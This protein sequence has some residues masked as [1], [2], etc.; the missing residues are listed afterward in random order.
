[1]SHAAPDRIATLDIIRGVAVLGILAMNVVDFA[2]P[3]E[4]YANPEAYGSQGAADYAA[5][6]VGFILFDGKMR[7]LF[8]LLFGASMLLVIER[9]DARGDNSASIHFRRMLWLGMIGLLHFYL[10]WH[11]DILFGYA[12]AGMAAWFFHQQEPEELLRWGM[13]FLLVEFALNAVVSAGYFT[14]AAAAAAP[15]ATAR[16]VAQWQAIERSHGAPGSAA[17][18]DT[19]ALYR[20]PYSGILHYRLTA[21]GWSPFKG[22]LLYTWE[23]IGFMLLGMAALKSGFLIGAWPERRYRR[24]AAV[25][26]GVSLPAYA[27]LAWLIARSGF[28][29]PMLAAAGD[30]AAALVRP[31]MV[32]GLA[33]AIILLARGGMLTRRIAAAGRAA[34]TNYLGASLLMTSLFY[35]Y[36]FGLFGQLGRAELWLAVLPAWALMLLWPAPWL[37]R[38]LYGP[39]EWLWR[40]LA[41]GTPQPM[42]R[43]RVAATPG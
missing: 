32:I 15:D 14:M 17:I 31:A 1:M 33:A 4:A 23:A 16:A 5:W 35:G 12:V 13:A 25:A 27:L 11:G 36:G 22:L 19:L 41:R 37:E 3:A 8:S 40:S 24:V 39:F 43:R 28:S 18:A 6:A 29:V 34:F 2:M 42:R 30:A 7:G 20:G 21:L 10:I 9:A 26:L 38:F